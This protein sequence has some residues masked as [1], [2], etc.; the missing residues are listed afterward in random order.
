[1]IGGW[2]KLH[3]EELHNLYF[4]PRLITRSVSYVT[5]IAQMGEK[6]DMYRILFGN[7]QGK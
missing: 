5:H 4:L 2:R 3:N 6:R 7:P 1:V